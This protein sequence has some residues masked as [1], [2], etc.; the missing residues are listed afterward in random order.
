M[1][2]D[3]LINNAAVLLEDWN[4]PVI[5]MKQ[6]R[7]TF[8]VNVFGTIALT[9]Q[10]LPLM[11]PGAHIINIGSGWGSVSEKGLDA[12]VPHYK[13]SKAALHM[14]TKVLAVRLQPRDIKVSAFD[15]GRVKSDM[16]TARA[17][18]APETAAHEI[19]NLFE[20]QVESGHFWDGKGR[21]TW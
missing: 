14:Y 15:P 16:G 2:F 8:E 9:E 19:V 21:R 20:S 6:L 18:K 5:D 3:G 13:M 17:R 4:D 10:L 12:S 1:R 7:Q 11:N